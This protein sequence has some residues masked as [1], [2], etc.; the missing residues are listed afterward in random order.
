MCL[1]EGGDRGNQWKQTKETSH[2][3]VHSEYIYT[4]VAWVLGRG[5]EGTDGVG[6]GSVGRGGKAVVQVLLGCTSMIR[7]QGRGKVVEGGG[8]QRPS[9]FF[10]GHAGWLAC[11]CSP[12][13]WDALCLASRAAICEAAGR[14][15]AVQ[16]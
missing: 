1:L 13:L 7:Q 11:P 12:R 15:R 3:K 14:R 9:S 4:A 10:T 8:G 6:R 16:R 5:S 2:R